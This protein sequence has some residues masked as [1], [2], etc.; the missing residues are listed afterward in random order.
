MPPINM[1]AI[2]AFFN[3][4]PVRVVLAIICA[5]FMV[6]GIYRVNTA[7]NNVQMFRGGGE[8][9]LWGSWLLVNVLFLFGKVA[10]KINI[11]INTGLVMIIIS[12]FMKP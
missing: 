9:L 1:Q 2:M 4:R 10:R 5:V 11:A 6:Q 8:I 3:R 12:M 7:T